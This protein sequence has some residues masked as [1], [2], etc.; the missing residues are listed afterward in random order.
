MWEVTVT[1]P[2]TIQEPVALRPPLPGLQPQLRPP[3]L[4]P[5]PSAQLGFREPSLEA[6]LASSPLAVPILPA[7]GQLL[8]PFG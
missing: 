3:P 5:L 7:P 1:L 4:P 8:G 2:L 6:L